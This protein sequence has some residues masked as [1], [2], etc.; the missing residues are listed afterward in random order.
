MSGA[1]APRIPA[2]DLVTMSFAASSQSKGGVLLGDKKFAANSI[3]FHT[4]ALKPDD[5]PKIL[6]DEE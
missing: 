3:A 5:L 1:T 6:P 4:H 2:A